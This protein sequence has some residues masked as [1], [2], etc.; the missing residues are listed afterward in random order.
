M[1][2]TRHTG[3]RQ[4][5]REMTYA[6]LRPELGIDWT[7][8]ELQLRDLEGN[9]IDF[10]PKTEWVKAVCFDGEL[11]GLYVLTDDDD[12]YFTCHSIDLEFSEEKPIDYKAMTDG[13]ILDCLYAVIN[14][15]E[16]KIQQLLK[17][18]EILKEART[19]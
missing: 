6:R 4:K 15:D 1:L 19:N 2:F 3:A 16:M 17:I 7:N 11:T 13:E 8:G 10:T 5:E 18:D 12:T 9:D 14:N